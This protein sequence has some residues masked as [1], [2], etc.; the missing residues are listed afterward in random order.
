MFIPKDA[1]QG[2]SKQE[3]C[4]RGVRGVVYRNSAEFGPPSSELRKVIKKKERINNCT[5][6]NST[7]IYILIVPTSARRLYAL[8]R[9]YTRL[10]YVAYIGGY[11]G[12]Y[13]LYTPYTRL[14]YVLNTP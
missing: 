6:P 4:V 3:A 8:Y 11:T 13:A 10:T 7:N 14:I 5:Y 1:S 9:P 12:L 2:Y